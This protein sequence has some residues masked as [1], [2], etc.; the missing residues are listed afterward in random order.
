MPPL[1]NPE[2][3]DIEHT[4][5]HELPGL[6]HRL[7]FE[8]GPGPIGNAGKIYH[9]LAVRELYEPFFDDPSQLFHPYFPFGCDN[10]AQELWVID[11][12]IE[13]AASIW[14]ETVPDAWPDEEWLPYDSWIERY[15][16]P[17]M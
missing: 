2:I 16:E 8:L 1:T 12:S 17:D 4:L 14:H 13:Q 9:P 5:G 3:E 11:A 6:Y 10:K 15:L 7:L